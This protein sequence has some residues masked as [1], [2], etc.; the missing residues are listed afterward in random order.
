MTRE[1]EMKIVIV[2]DVL[3]KP[4]NGTTLAAYNLIG[5][6]KAQGHSVRVVCAD[7][8]RAGT[9]GFF[10]VPI[11]N[12]GPLNLL[13]KA[14]NVYLA[15]ADKK[16][17]TTAIEGAD[18]VHVLMPF[19]LGVTA[20]KLAKQRGIPVTASFHA[21]AENVTAHLACMNNRLA[22]HITYLFFYHLLYKRVDVIHY[23]TQFIRE[24][25]ERQIKREL[26]CRVISNGV[27]DVFF[28][29]R[30]ERVRE[31]KFVIF[32]MGRFSK[33]KAQQT[34]IKAVAKCPFKE[35]IKLCFAGCGPKEKMLKRLARR[36]KVDA[37][38]RFYSREQLPLALQR[39]DLYVHTA[40]VEI[41]AISCLEA[42]AAGLV[43]IICNSP[44]SATKNFA[45]DENCLFK[46]GDSRDLAQ[47]ISRFYSAPEQIDA[48]RE[49]YR[50]FKQQFRQT[51]CMMRMEQ[52]L[53]ETAAAA[54]RAKQEENKVK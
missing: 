52:M 32:C 47:K 2:C 9:P 20:C 4:N 18:V 48:Y 40:V 19:P 37:D 11:K 5:F 13:L 29:P 43:P 41:E 3:G 10:V 42:I 54:K 14:N 7:K 50:S 30:P 49:K 24:L 27:N 16:V 8:E 35:Q 25:F 17:L 33:E 51:D 53:E 34:L 21:Q 31:G 22:N 44:R 23:P 15:K 26:P 36:K 45:L 1:R 28:A 46:A 12:L 6:L 38:F 39:A